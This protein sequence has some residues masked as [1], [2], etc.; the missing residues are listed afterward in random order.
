ML[1]YSNGTD[2]KLKNAKRLFYNYLKI[3]QRKSFTTILWLCNSYAV[4]F[5]KYKGSSIF[6][7]N[8][9]IRALTKFRKFHEIYE[10]FKVEIFNSQH[11]FQGTVDVGWI[12]VSQTLN[13]KIVNVDDLIKKLRSSGYG[14]HIGSLFVA[15]CMLTILY[16]CH[17][18]VLVS[19]N[20]L[21]FVNSLHLT[22][23]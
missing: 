1:W 9:Q 3:K 13:L 23:H 8:F 11:Y 21:T 19:K 4:L 17:H 15:F 2:K 20:F 5:M 22:A 16:Y 6:Q 10:T 14:L 7:W 18:H 12:G